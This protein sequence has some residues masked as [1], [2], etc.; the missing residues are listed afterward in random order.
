MFPTLNPGLQAFI[1]AAYGV[2]QLL[3]LASVLPHARRYFVSDRWGGYAQSSPAVDAVQNPVMS[4]VVLAIWFASAAC[5]VVGRA[6]VPAAGINLALCYYFFIWMRWHGVLRGMGA[7][8]FIAFW[9]GAAVFLLE[10][11]TRY[12]PTLG[13]LALLTVQVDFALIMISA[14]IYKLVSGYRSGNGMELGMVN[15]A[16]GYWASMWRGWRPTNPLFRFLDEM[17]WGTEVAAGVL[18]LIPQT[19]LLGGLAILLSFV[20]IATQIRL[21]FLCEMV[22][23][24]CLLFVPGGSPADVA[25]A[26]AQPTTLLLVG[27]MGFWTYLALLPVVRAG[28]YYNQLAHKAL[29]A[30]LQRALDGYTN[31]FGLI[32]WR[33]FTADVVNFFVRVWDEPREGRE[34][35]SRRLLSDYEGFTWTRRFRQVA[36][37]IAVTSV[38]TTLR[39]YASNR[40]LFVER[41]LRYARTIPRRP[42]TRLIFEWVSVVKGNDRFEF[43]TIAEYHVDVDAGTVDDVVISGRVTVDRVAPESPIHEGVRPGSYVPLQR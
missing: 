39:Y 20:F 42:A 16:W 11:T 10:F 18:M 41:L 35:G 3:T 2:L 37:C 1:R 12:A 13:P 30:P 28:M 15:P 5:L 21:G 33:V 31:L 27:A 23:V 43:V 36:E 14:G 40:Q 26:I 22:V 24:C 25:P 34:A 17:A 7:P 29:P 6:V 32:I 8:G 19:R 9:L 38:F 4:T